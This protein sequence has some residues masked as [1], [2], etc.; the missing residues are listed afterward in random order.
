MIPEKM[1]PNTSAA[2]AAL[3][4]VSGTA[5]IMLP[6]KMAGLGGGG[7]A[8]DASARSQV[9]AALDRFPGAGFHSYRLPLQAGDAALEVHVTEQALDRSPGKPCSPG[10]GQAQQLF[11]P[12]YRKRPG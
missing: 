9:Q 8:P 5:R 6:H 4:P 2:L 7:D 11:A 1:P 3:M 12:N 10:I